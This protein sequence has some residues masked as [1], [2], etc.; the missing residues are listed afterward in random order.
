[1]QD[2]DLSVYGSLHLQS[3]QQELRNFAKNIILKYSSIKML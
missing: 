3:E 2:I 1:M